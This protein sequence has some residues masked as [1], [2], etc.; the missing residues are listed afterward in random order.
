MTTE[1]ERA[2]IWTSTGEV[3]LSSLTIWA[4]MIGV[5]QLPMDVS[6]PLDPDDFG[7]C[8][9]LLLLIPEWRDR[10][11]EVAAKYSEW[12]PLV[13]EWAPLTEMYEAALNSG[14]RTAPEMYAL[15]KGLIQEGRQQVNGYQC[16]I[17][18]ETTYFRHV[19]AGTTP[20][21]MGCKATEGCGGRMTSMMYRVPQGADALV[22]YEWF[23]PSDLKGY[24]AEMREHIKKGGL[25]HRP[26]SG[27]VE[28][29]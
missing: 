3:G 18:G 4:V 17:C 8:Y 21:F 7:R 11:A 14:A 9:K 20:M 28:N 23:K 2:M 27:V 26:V 24:S 5:L 22:R 16:G 25:D 29:Q 19:D 1:A 10:L 15:M 6:V 12:R 13:R